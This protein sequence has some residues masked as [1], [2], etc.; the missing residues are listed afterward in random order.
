MN[1]TPRIRLMLSCSVSPVGFVVFVKVPKY[2]LNLSI[3]CSSSKH[4]VD[5]QILLSKL[6]MGFVRPNNSDLGFSLTAGSERRIQPLK[7]K[8]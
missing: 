7:K 8:K 6:L 1:T 2:K 5:K 3:F 4:A